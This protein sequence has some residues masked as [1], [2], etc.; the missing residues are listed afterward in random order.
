MNQ[1][2]RPVTNEIDQKLEAKVM[3]LKPDTAHPDDLLLT[4]YLDGELATD[5]GHSA[6]I[7]AQLLSDEAS[8]LRL[9]VLA[10]GGRPFRQAFAALGEQ[11]PMDRLMAGLKVA[12]GG[13]KSNV[14]RMRAGESRWTSPQALAA[15]IALVLAGAGAGLVAAPQIAHPLEPWLHW[16]GLPALETAALDHDDA[17]MSAVASQVSL[18]DSN[19]IAELA[20][21]PAR[22]AGELQAVAAKLGLSLQERD[23]ALT[24]YTF[25][26]AR[27]LS[28]SGKPI[29]QLLYV[30][31]TDGPLALCISVEKDEGKEPPITRDDGAVGMRYWRN[32][33]RGLLLAGRIPQRRLLELAEAVDQLKL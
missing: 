29:A 22:S 20:P 33:S 4:A 6:D 12:S 23:I 1:A 18:E 28:F 30:S 32:N 17:W 31:A 19:T 21:D 26:K 10:A 3:D 16:V 8:R 24:G 14:Y 11:A 27:L 13:R 5:A 9:A 15:S 7:E 25:K 2:V